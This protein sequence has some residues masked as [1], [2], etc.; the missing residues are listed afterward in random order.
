M[1]NTGEKQ[2]ST[3]WAALS[4]KWTASGLPQK[5][6]CAQR[7]IDYKTFVYRR[8]K[9]KPINKGSVALKIVA[10]PSKVSKLVPLNVFEGVAPAPTESAN[11]AQ[12]PLS[13]RSSGITITTPTGHCIQIQDDFDEQTLLRV[14][15]ALKAAKWSASHPIESGLHPVLPTCANPLMAWRPLPSTP[16]V[17][18]QQANNYLASV[19]AT[20]V[21]SIQMAQGCRHAPVHQP[22]T[23]HRPL[24]ATYLSDFAI[25]ANKRFNWSCSL[26][27][28]DAYKAKSHLGLEHLWHP[29]LRQ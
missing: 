13:P 4:E 22:Q 24:D 28:T 10:P 5:D 16:S 23:A 25:H 29:A 6:F 18:I 20:G 1:V 21:W 27:V 14:L 3:S 12:S 9:C 26:Y 7:G 8:S 19:Q 17:K 15:K 2:D 11:H